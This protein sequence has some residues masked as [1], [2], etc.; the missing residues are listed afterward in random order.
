MSRFFSGKYAQ[1]TP[2]VPGEQPQDQ[3]YIKLNT[4]ESPFPPSPKAIAKASEAAKRL[5]LYSDPD[6][7][8]L[9]KK[10]ADKFGVEPENVIIGNGSDEI[11][12][13][14]FMAFCDTDTPAIFPDI[15]YGFYPVFSEAGQIPYVEMPLRDDFTID[16]NDYAKA[17]G[18]VFIA[19]PNAHTGVALTREELEGIVQANPD[20]VVV[21]DEAYVDFGAES[22]IEMTKKYDNVIVVQTMSKSRSLAGA[23]LGYGIACGELIRDMNTLRNSTNPYNIN[24]MTMAAAEGVLD[25]E[26]YTAAN[27][28]TVIENREFTVNELRKLG[29][30]LTDS[31]AN[32]VFMKHPEVDGGYIY[33]TLKSK[34]VLVRHFTKERICQ[35]NRVTIGSRQQMEIFIEK[36]K[37]IVNCETRAGGSR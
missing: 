31:V 32:F 23:R 1:L 3:Q 34:G 28:R 9:T 12:N 30:E 20:N 27:C 33:E 6:V 26:E 29:F 22:C 10:L 4:N 24:S 7:R 16:V 21:I 2:Y 15:T 37:D 25:D 18:T 8:V 19:N 14:A 5:N 35:Y 13:F 36:L 11:L 17:G